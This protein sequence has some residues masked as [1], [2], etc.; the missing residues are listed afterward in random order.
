MTV[1]D[2]ITEAVCLYYEYMSFM[3]THIDT[4][5]NRGIMSNWQS[6]GGY[7]DPRKSFATKESF[8]LSQH[9]AFA[10]MADLM[11]RYTY[12]VNKLFEIQKS[13]TW[14]LSLVVPENDYI[15]IMTPDTNT[16]LV[17]PTCITM[18]KDGFPL[19]DHIKYVSDGWVEIALGGLPDNTYV[20]YHAV[21]F[22]VLNNK[23]IQVDL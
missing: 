11:S 3:Q 6:H 20:K 18:D 1:N 9:C 23:L 16:M 12:Y 4:L 14:D 7:G 10:G 5:R 22:I 15:G 17:L 19:I 21:T 2:Q 8:M 13:F